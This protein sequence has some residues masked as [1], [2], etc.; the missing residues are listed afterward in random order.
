MSPRAIRKK[1]LDVGDLQKVEVFDSS[2]QK[3]LAGRGKSNVTMIREGLEITFS[4]LSEAECADT[5]ERRVEKYHKVLAESSLELLR[6]PEFIRT[7]V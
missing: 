4:G 5:V 3:P 7:K 1:K 6:N 2:L